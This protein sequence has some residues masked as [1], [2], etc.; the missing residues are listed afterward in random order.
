VS[1]LWTVNFAMSAAQAGV[2]QVDLHSSLEACKGGPPLSPIC[3]SGPYRK[4]SGDISMR[5]AYYGMML[6]NSVG[7]GE[8]QKVDTSGNENIYAYAVKHGDGSMSVVVVNQND[9]STT[10]QAPVSIKLPQAAGTGTMSQMTG[11]SFDAQGQTRIDGLESAGVPKAAQARIPGFTAG[12]QDV[13]VALTS[14]TA[15]VLT[16]TF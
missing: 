10:A 3:D 2:S 6:V 16:F 7:A 9:P 5:P 15:T 4:P 11:P 14:G 12:S 13:K 8:F 1:A